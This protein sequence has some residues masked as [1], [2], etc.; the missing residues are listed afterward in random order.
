MTIREIA[1]EA[2]L[3]TRV[4][5]SFKIDYCCGGR[6][7]FSEA[8][9]KAGVET[10]KVLSQL[11]L[12]LKD[13]A[14]GSA[15]LAERKGAVELIDYIVQKH[16]VFTRSELTRLLPLAE[17]VWSRH[18]ENHPELLKI[19][20][21]LQELADE[22]FVHMRKEE[23]VLFP[24]IEQLSR[25]VAHG[26]AVQT[27]HFGSVTNPVRMMM[28]EHDRAGDMLK[29]MR[30]LSSDFTPPADSCPSYQGLYAGIEDLEKDLHRHIHLENNVLFPRA[31][32]NEEACVK[33]PVSTSHSCG[34]A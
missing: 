16:H 4:F 20:N 24:Y 19:R 31:I 2:P 18:G 21:I 7:P 23:A 1:L 32:A 10:S 3:T 13:D 26:G 25:A 17:K 28:F 30:S 12:V 27:P 29:D 22:L 11:E 15:D 8:C 34:V 5:E 14:N 6:V 9:E 33:G